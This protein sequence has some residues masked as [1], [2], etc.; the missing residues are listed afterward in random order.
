[1]CIFKEGL[2]TRLSRRSLREGEHDTQNHE[3]ALWA[4]RVARVKGRQRDAHVLEELKDSDILSQVFI[5]LS[6]VHSILPLS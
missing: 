1:M 2:R 3:R 4:R 5:F 6:C